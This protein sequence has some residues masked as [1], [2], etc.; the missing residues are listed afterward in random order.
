MFATFGGHVARRGQT[1]LRLLY[2]RL[3]QYADEEDA[4]R[5]DVKLLV[6]YDDKL[7]RPTHS[8]FAHYIASDSINANPISADSLF[9][10]VHACPHHWYMP[11]KNE[12]RERYP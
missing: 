8:I 10:Y 3:H 11:V 12:G 6:Q 4:V 9:F 5:N 1:Y 2:D 7:L